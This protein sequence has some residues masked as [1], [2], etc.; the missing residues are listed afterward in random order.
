MKLCPTILTIVFLAV[1]VC[2]GNEWRMPRDQFERFKNRADPR[3]DSGSCVQAS[4]SMC[5]AHHGVF[6]FEFLLEPSPYGPAELG[7]STPGRVTKYAQ[8]RGVPIYSI[9][10]SETIPW[11]EWALL[12]GCYVGITYGRAHMIT[13]IAMAEDGSWF[14]IVDN[15][16]PSEVRRVDRNTFIHEH[17]VH[18]GG[19][20]VIL[21]TPGPAPWASCRALPREALWR[22]LPREGIG[23]SCKPSY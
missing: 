15:N 10:G 11:I 18:G 2:A 8:A 6:A 3:D 22:A 12:R 23:Q 14:E 20:C 9:E 16:W 5:G 7:G 21:Q 19:W 17:R 4:L 1:A 13:A